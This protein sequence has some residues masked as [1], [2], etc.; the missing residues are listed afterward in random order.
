MVQEVL[1]TGVMQ[2]AETPVRKLEETRR[3]EKSP[4]PTSSK[5]ITDE[6]IHQTAKELNSAV[7]VLN[8]RLSFTV[9]GKTGKN[10][11]R[12]VDGESGKVIRQIPPE[13]ALRISER[14]KELLGGLVDKH[15]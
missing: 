15:M 10:I 3:Q 5:G 8:T 14:I 7:K 1:A 4:P 9:D 11:I 12:I 2:V 13:E 6:Q